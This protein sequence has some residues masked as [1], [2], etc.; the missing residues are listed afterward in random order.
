MYLNIISYFDRN[1]IDELLESLNNPKTEIDNQDLIDELF[2][3]YNYALNDFYDA[4]Y[5][6]LKSG[7]I[8]KLL[9][10]LSSEI[11][12]KNIRLTTHQHKS[13]LIEIINSTS[14]NNL[15][16]LAN[17]LEGKEVDSK[18]LID[19]L[20][21]LPDAILDYLP[22]NNAF[23]NALNQLVA[24]TL[25]AVGDIAMRIKTLNTLNQKPIGDHLNLTVFQ[26]KIVTLHD[27]ELRH[28]IETANI[29]KKKTEKSSVREASLKAQGSLL[30]FYNP[31]DIDSLPELQKN[32]RLAAQK[33]IKRFYVELPTE[34][35]YV[36]KRLNRTGNTALLPEIFAQ[37]HKS[38]DDSFAPLKKTKKNFLEI[39]NA[40]KQLNILHRLIETAYENKLA[41]F[42]VAES[43]YDFIYAQISELGLSNAIENY[44]RNVATNIS[45]L[46]WDETQ[47]EPPYF[48]GAFSGLISDIASPHHL[49]IPSHLIL[50]T[51]EGRD[52]V[53]ATLVKNNDALGKDQSTATQQ[54]RV[55]LLFKFSTL[56]KESAPF[57]YYTLIKPSEKNRLND[58]LTVDLP[59]IDD[60]SAENFILKKMFEKQKGLPLS[61]VDAVNIYFVISQLNNKIISNITTNQSDKE[62]LIALADEAR[63]EAKKFAAH[64]TQ[65]LPTLTGTPIGELM[66]L[67]P[68][69]PEEKLNKVLKDK[70][71]V[72]VLHLHNDLESYQAL[73]DEL[74]MLAQTA[75][76][77]IEHLYLELPR[78]TYGSLLEEFNK[79]GDPSDI[80]AQLNQSHSVDPN[81]INYFIWLM[82]AAHSAN[83]N[84][85]AVDSSDQRGTFLLE[86]NYNAFT[87]SL[88]E[89]NQEMEANIYDY[90]PDLK[91]KF[92]FLIG[93]LHYD[94]AKSLHV[95][96]IA[97]VPSNLLTKKDD[98]TEL[99]SDLTHEEQLAISLKNILLTV[100]L[101]CHTNSLLLPVINIIGKTLSSAYLIH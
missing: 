18:N 50:S 81:S 71:G 11:I 79:T 95:D 41:V 89:S 46:N 2:M 30:Y 37:L 29:T 51:Q 85:F 61:T 55:S 4:N 24:N 77:G 63:I 15:L 22:R 96:N 101:A 53:I 8:E 28:F 44:I 25:N 67:N 58:T 12:R 93:A 52:D 27:K 6:D 1:N 23:H 92:L 80:A 69:I 73:I 21:T 94:V 70:P 34:L 3:V 56:Y 57:D 64:F 49:D 31:S 60:T 20:L 59:L 33:G 84:V 39:E 78:K 36:F 75:L 82:Q 76:H 40:H 98:A 32:I 9:H 35:L 91:H 86:G 13:T 100:T 97:F 16:T 74:P 45:L 38:I 65:P 7:N 17:A 83:I 43:I 26:D 62:T 14:L 42:P 47:K 90:N 48:L 99:K 19:A 5:G 87:Q 10:L 54:K 88:K 72:V 66:G 68:T